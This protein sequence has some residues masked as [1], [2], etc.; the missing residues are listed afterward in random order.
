MDIKNIALV[1][2][3][4]VVVAVSSMDLGVPYSELETKIYTNK[5][6][7]LLAIISI[8]YLNTENINLTLLIFSLWF[9]IKYFK[10]N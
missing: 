5:I 7:Q 1:I 6:F 10:I 2:S 4:L 8:A 9:I 3:T